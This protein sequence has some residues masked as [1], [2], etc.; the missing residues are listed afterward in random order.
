M[1][2]LLGPRQNVSIVCPGRVV[3]NFVRGEAVEVENAQH[4]NFLLRS[5][6]HNFTTVL[7]EPKKPKA[8]KTKEEPKE[9]PKRRRRSK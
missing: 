1:I 8:E 2:K 7:E 4:V 6:H 5:T 3:Y 9:K